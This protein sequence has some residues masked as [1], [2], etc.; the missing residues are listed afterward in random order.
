[1]ALVDNATRNGYRFNMKLSAVRCA[2]HLENQAFQHSFP[3]NEPPD[4]P[5]LEPLNRTKINAKLSIFY[6]AFEPITEK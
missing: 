4:E 5:P 6:S 1:V 2:V 3:L